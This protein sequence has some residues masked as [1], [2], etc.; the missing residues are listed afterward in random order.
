MW[1]CRHCDA[2]GKEIA[3]DGWLGTG[4]CRRCGSRDIFQDDAPKMRSLLFSN[5]V[6]HKGINVTCRNGYKWAN[7]MGELVTVE[8][9]EGSGTYGEAHIL[10]VLTCKRNAIPETILALE[11]DPSCRTSKG[12]ITEMK[13]V[14]GPDLPED[15][16][17]TVLM[18]EF[19]SDNELIKQQKDSRHNQ[20]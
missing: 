12:I 20:W 6:F 18:F 1:K 14:Y 7:A 17:T 16:P 8:D 10:G 15:A 2:N 13:R 3:Y 11:H 19:E 4:E 5:P 9:T